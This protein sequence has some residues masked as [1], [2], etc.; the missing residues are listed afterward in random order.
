[1]KDE[2]KINQNKCI[3][4]AR[5]DHISILFILYL[6][7]KVSHQQLHKKEDDEEKKEEKKEEND[8]DD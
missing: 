1:M 6:M 2:K 7:E 3:T 8:D 5:Q 4:F